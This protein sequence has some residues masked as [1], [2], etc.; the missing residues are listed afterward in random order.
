[1]KRETG[2]AGELM[3]FAWQSAAIA[4][5]ACGLVFY[6]STSTSFTDL[7]SWTYD[8][9]V[10]AGGDNSVSKDVV[11][12]DFDEESFARIAR[13][14]IPRGTFAELLTKIA[15]QQPRI[16]GMDILLSE[17]RTPEEDKAMQ[18]ALSS[19]QNVVLASQSSNGILPPAIPLPIFCQPDDPRS[20]S[21][22]CADGSPLP[23]ALGYAFVNM[24]FDQDGFIRQAVLIDDGPPRSESFPL[25]LAELY[26]GEV[27]KAVDKTHGT[28]L[29]HPV[30]FA[31]PGGT[32]MLIGSWSRQPVT[33]I[34]AWKLLAGQTP[35]NAL[36]DKLVLIGQTND[37]AR[38]QLLTP[39]FRHADP[40]GFRKRLGGT[41]IHAAAIRSL[42]EGKVV[43]PA[44][45]PQRWTMVFLLAWASSFL[46]L[47]LRPPTVGVACAIVLAI[48][49]SLLAVYLYAHDR[50][51][52]PFLPSQ[53]GVELTLPLSLG[54]QFVLER[55]VA[56]EAREQRK[57]LMKLFSSYV[58][59]AVAKTIWERR[60]EVSLSGEER[61][62]TV[63]FTDIRNFTKLS[64][65]R[66]PAEVLR[67]LN[68]YVT[69]MDKVIRRYDGFLNKFIGDGLMII[70]GLPL[71]Q[72]PSEDARLA[73]EASLA[74]LES[75]KQLNQLNADN[76]A[77]PQLRIGVGIHTGPLMAGSIG[78]A[79]RQEYSVIGATVNLASRLESLN[80]TF[81]TEILMSKAT[82]DMVAREF[83]GLRSMGMASVAGLEDQI[84]VFT[85]D[86]PEKQQ[87]EKYVALLE[88][89]Q[90]GQKWI[91]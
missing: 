30:Y 79:S 59:P 19:A 13:Y 64:A 21:G 76:P 6:A 46:L 87:E 17:A 8:F 50:F 1:M 24:D 2:R 43:R 41:E 71:S 33:V 82:H 48:F 27:I 70:F 3:R 40:N 91:T 42:L 15:A 7:D 80:K 44:T 26:K 38:D 75:V 14:P 83:S 10:I 49:P 88:Q 36:K 12:V 63:V 20:A 81:K 58:D 73:I 62:A 53:I 54:L 18:A 77:I 4:A 89:G 52:L 72:G 61:V 51:W 86:P 90:G 69:E 22:Y 57:Q 78:S 29:G 55:L 85:I 68:M 32:T 84:E 39:V 60:S 28:F 37:A 47:A 23:G 65:G 25:L 9:T 74:M 11:L 34:P 66:H 67:W 31:K 45:P 35:P 5:V 16:V 56:R